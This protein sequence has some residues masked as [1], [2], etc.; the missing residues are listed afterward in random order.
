MGEVWPRPALDPATR[1]LAAVA[2]FATL[3]D[4]WP[5]MRLHVGHALRMGVPRDTLREIINLLTVSAGFPIALNA[6]GEM[7]KVF[8]EF[9][10]QTT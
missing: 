2:A 9:D 8:A 10:G 3:G 5:Q 7:A 4:A 1:Q 6:A